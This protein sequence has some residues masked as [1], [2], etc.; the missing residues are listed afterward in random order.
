MAA[1]ALV[2]ILAGCSAA[3]SPSVGTEASFLRAHGLNG[4]DA[5]EIVDHRERLGGAD[6]PTDLMASVRPDQLLL[7]HGKRQVALAMPE[8][9]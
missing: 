1:A 5:P 7:T 3:D 6:R 2:L 9:R 8:D 4:M